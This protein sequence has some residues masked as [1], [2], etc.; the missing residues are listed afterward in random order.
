M[1]NEIYVIERCLAPGLWEL[2][3]PHYY[4]NENSA[5]IAEENIKKEMIKYDKNFKSRVTTLKLFK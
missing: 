2:M 4:D 1:E 5:N 3:G